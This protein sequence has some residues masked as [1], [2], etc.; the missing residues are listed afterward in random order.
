MTFN[1]CMNWIRLHEPILHIQ[2]QT[3]IDQE[4]ERDEKKS[5]ERKEKD[6]IT[7][8]FEWL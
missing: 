3:H 5:R 6:E 1:L 8:L 7:G 4:N 2:T